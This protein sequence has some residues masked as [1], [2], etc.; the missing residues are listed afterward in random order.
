[1][2]WTTPKNAHSFSNVKNAVGIAGM[3]I[4][5]NQIL[6]FH[7]N[8][9]KGKAVKVMTTLPDFTPCFDK[10]D[11]LTDVGD[12]T[13]LSLRASGNNFV[14]NCDYVVGIC[15]VNKGWE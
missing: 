7:R 5:I 14:L 4:M 15:I 8:L 12:N 3:M 9:E 11:I 2:K 6:A 13:L 1:M 10:T